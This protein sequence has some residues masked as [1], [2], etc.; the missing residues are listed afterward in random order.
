MPSYNAPI[1]DMQFVLHEV[2][3][4]S[5]ELKKFKAYEDIDQDVINQILEEAS[6]FAS[7]VLQP[8]NQAGD[9]MG[10]TRNQDGSVKTPT[11]FKEAY[12]KDKSR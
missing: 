8:T 7:E 3:N 11:G 5:A 4:V 12:A 6:K 10:C 1:R 2:F 9:L